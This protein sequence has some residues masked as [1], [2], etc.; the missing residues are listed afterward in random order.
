[1]YGTG[2]VHQQR[3]GLAFFVVVQLLLELLAHWAGDFLDHVPIEPDE[4]ERIDGDSGVAA[5]AGGATL[6][7][8]ERAALCCFAAGGFEE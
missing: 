3:A 4:F 6:V 1:V 2:V 8:G 5:A 7:A